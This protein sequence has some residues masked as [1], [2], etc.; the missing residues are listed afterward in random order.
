MCLLEAAATV[1]TIFLVQFAAD[2]RFKLLPFSSERTNRKA[3]DATVA[4]MEH[5]LELP[6]A[7]SQSAS[8]VS[9]ESSPALQTLNSAA[10]TFPPVHVGSHTSDASSFIPTSMLLY[11]QLAAYASEAVIPRTDCP[12]T[13]WADNWQKYPLV[14]EVVRRLL[15]IPAVT[16]STERL[17][18][19]KGDEFMDKRDAMSP[20]KADQVLFIM[21]NL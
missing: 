6:S 13:W 21:E 11:Q 15:V 19:K 20:E 1:C 8:S 3:T 2:P 16:V 9:T 14:F 4:L 5:V 10:S 17:Y 18:T 7:S 12:L